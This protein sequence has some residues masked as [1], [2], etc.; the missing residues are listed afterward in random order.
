MRRDSW[1]RGGTFSTSGGIS[2]RLTR[3][4]AFVVDA[5]YT[6]L[7]VK[8][9]AAAPRTNDGLFNLRALLNYTFR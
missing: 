6:P 4:A 5:F 2:Y 8:R 7:W 9:S 1:T 3:H